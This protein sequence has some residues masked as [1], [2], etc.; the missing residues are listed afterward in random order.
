[1]RFGSY[2]I[3]AFV[4]AVGLAFGASA[5]AACPEVPPVARVPSTGS[6]F[7]TDNKGVTRLDTQ[8]SDNVR[9]T[10]GCIDVPSL[11]VSGVPVGQVPGMCDAFVADD[12]TTATANGVTTFTS[13]SAT[14][15]NTDVGKK[16]TINGAGPTQYIKSVT[17]SAA[18]SGYIRGEVITLD[19]G[20]GTAGKVVV[21]SVDGGGGV[22]T[23]AGYAGS[24]GSYT[25]IPGN[26]VA[27]AST[28]IPGTGDPGLGTGATF[29]VTWS[30]DNLV[31]TIARVIDTHN[32]V[33]ADAATLDGSSA[34]WAFGTDYAAEINAAVASNP[35]M[36]PAGKCGVASSANLESL[37]VLRGQGRGGY[38]QAATTLVWLGPVNGSVISADTSGS[39]INGAT[40]GPLNVEGMCSASRGA[41]FYGLQW[42]DVDILSQNTKDYGFELSGDATGT[43][44]NYNNQ[45]R[46]VGVA[47]R[48]CSQAQ[49]NL[50]FTSQVPGGS[51][52]DTNSN[53]FYEYEGIHIDGNSIDFQQ[54]FLNT[55]VG[56]TQIYDGTGN[57]WGVRFGGGVALFNSR[58]NIIDTLITQRPVLAEGSGSGRT[59]SRANWIRGWD[60]GAYDPGQTVESG[61]TLFC[62]TVGQDPNRCTSHAF[63]SFDCGNPTGT[64]TTA[65]YVAMGC[66]GTFTP[67]YTG[68]VTIETSGGIT[69]N[70]ATRGALATMYYGTGT[71][72]ANGDNIETA[73]SAR[74][75]CGPFPALINTPSTTFITPFTAACNINGL[76]PGTTYW[77]DLGL[78][79]SG[80]GTASIANAYA[81]ANELP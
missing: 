41:K 53:I 19:G 66:G 34:F 29:T 68:R 33:L 10:G 56:L 5:R 48:S 13:A 71:P 43:H 8:T 40:I 27:Q 45:Y 51:D 20:T 22:V 64:A 72:P 62:V 54:A 14:F 7:A 31:T 12:G 69:N 35:T 30:R 32:V 70:T 67:N 73:G 55:F 81:R 44:D 9:I 52:H 18:G 6:P 74:T 75:R 63:S 65:N 17:P 21:R 42:S 61:A 60:T 23:A 77:Y 24:L 11:Q 58:E 46:V 25:A 79:A 2:C 37:Y 38:E 26:A 36:L 39:R 47:T 4:L 80:A 78:K 16:I 59:A 50:A 76:I 57:G 3:A 28:V 1:M 15:A 49:T